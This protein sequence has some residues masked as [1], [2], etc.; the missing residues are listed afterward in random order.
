M[1]VLKDKSVILDDYKM[2]ALVNHWNANQLTGQFCDNTFLAQKM[3]QQAQNQYSRLEK[4]LPQP[5]T[6]SFIW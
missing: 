4:V 3:N 2:K 5:R 6:Q 1:N